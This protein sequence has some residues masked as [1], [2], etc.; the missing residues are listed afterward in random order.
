M[1][2][3]PSSAHLGE[4]D[5]VVGMKDGVSSLTCMVFTV[6]RALRTLATVQEQGRLMPRRQVSGRLRLSREE[7]TVAPATYGWQLFQVD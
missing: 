6:A 2:R 7:A 5:R 1:T 3:I 4:Q